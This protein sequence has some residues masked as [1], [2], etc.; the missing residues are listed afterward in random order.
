MKYLIGNII[1][2]SNKTS[3]DILRFVFNT[4]S[5]NI[6]LAQHTFSSNYR[7]LNEEEIIE[8]ECFLL[9]EDAPEIETVATDSLPEWAKQ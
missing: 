8:L 2:S 6:L 3:P 7:F 1:S 5:R 4:S 9:D